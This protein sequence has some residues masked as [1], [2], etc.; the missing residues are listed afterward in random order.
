[1]LAGIHGGL[2]G[3]YFAE[4]LLPDLFAGRLGE[5]EREDTR[6]ALARLTRATSLLGPAS[7]VRSVFDVA[8]GPLVEI[9]GYRTQSVVPS[10]DGARLVVTLEAGHARVA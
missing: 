5:H 10:A 9:L 7:S 4:C 8:A 3:E 2:V 6:A 1:M